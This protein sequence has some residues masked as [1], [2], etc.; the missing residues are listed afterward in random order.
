MPFGHRRVERV[1][2]DDKP[3]ELQARGIHFVMIDSDGMG[4]SSTTLGDWTNRLNGVVV[5]S[6]EIQAGVDNTITN[7]LVRLNPSGAN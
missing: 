3:A 2:P 7:Y 5:D 6:V 1:L 4:L